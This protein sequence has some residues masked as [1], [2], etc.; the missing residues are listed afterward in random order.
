MYSISPAFQDL[1]TDR[2]QLTEQLQQ[3][4]QEN[5][6]LKEQLERVTQE[7]TM[8]KEQYEKTQ[9]KGTFTSSGLSLSNSFLSLRFPFDRIIRFQ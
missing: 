8:A 6:V 3:V 1:S 7:L 2:N 5:G 9:L 4:N